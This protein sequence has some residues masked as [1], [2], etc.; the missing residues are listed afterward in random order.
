LGEKVELISQIWLCCSEK[1]LVPPVASSAFIIARQS[2]SKHL[3]PSTSTVFLGLLLD[4]DAGTAT[5]F[6]PSSLQERQDFPAHDY[7]QYEEV[8]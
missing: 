5:K 8:S 6:F 1:L 7:R 4:T 3:Q 2:F